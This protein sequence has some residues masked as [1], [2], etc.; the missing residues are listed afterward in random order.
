[1]DRHGGDER[2]LLGGGIRT[3]V[4]VPEGEGNLHPRDMPRR[5]MVPCLQEQRETSMV[6]GDGRHM[7]V[8]CQT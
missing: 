8:T 1:M 7:T 5:L 2:I 6:S 4:L 3:R